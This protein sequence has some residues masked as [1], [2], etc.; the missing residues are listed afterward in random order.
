MQRVFRQYVH[1]PHGGYYERHLDDH[2]DVAPGSS[3][4]VASRRAVSFILYLT[5]VDDPWTAEHGGAL[6]AFCTRKDSE[7]EPIDY[8]PMSGSL[9][10]FDSCRVEHAVMPTR[11][12][13]T[14][15]IGWFHTPA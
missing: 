3:A 10:I 14:C 6:R 1:Y 12:K 2:H 9:V 13:R 7:D 8:L 15:L 5:P 11:R 4:G